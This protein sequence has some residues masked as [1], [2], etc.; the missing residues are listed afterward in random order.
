MTFAVWQ[1]QGTVKLEAVPAAGQTGTET[2]SE[3]PK[4]HKAFMAQAQVNSRQSVLPRG[5]IGA[6]CT[7]Q[8]DIA[9]MT[10]D[11]LL[12]TGSK[13]TTITQ[14]FYNRNLGDQQIYPLD[15]LLE[16]ESANGQNVP[17][18]GYVEVTI[19]FPR[20]F[21]GIR[22]E[23][24]TLA[25]VIPDLPS[26]FQPSLLIGTN[27]LDELYKDFSQQK[28]RYFSPSYGYKQILKI[29]ELRQKQGVEGN[30][31]VVRLPEKQS[32]VIPAGQSTVLCGT[33][34]V[35]GVYPDKWVVIEHPSSSSL[36][37]GLIVKTCSYPWGE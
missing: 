28:P 22:M 19:T 36:P 23:V 11:C 37:G 3:C 30:V 4:Q 26:A 6:R 16:V 24:P 33:A 29:L 15:N 34:S 27:T 25:L 13:V 2:E 14:S 35:R 21:V 20:D 32:R 8:V 7:A 31:G 18:L 17:Y 10:C 9:G 1:P 5:L 12:D